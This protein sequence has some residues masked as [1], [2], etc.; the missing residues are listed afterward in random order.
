[1]LGLIV[2]NLGSRWI[3]GTFWS[4]NWSEKER[5]IRLARVVLIGL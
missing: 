1:M 3:E 5:L 2:T 4:D